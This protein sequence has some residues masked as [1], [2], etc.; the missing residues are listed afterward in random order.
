MRLNE[1]WN[2]N[3]RDIDKKTGYG[4]KYP[5]KKFPVRS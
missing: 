2:N 1:D 3:F 4:K 5:I